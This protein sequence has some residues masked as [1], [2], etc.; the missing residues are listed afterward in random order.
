MRLTYTRH[1]L[2]IPEEGNALIFDMDKMNNCQ[3]CGN[4]QQVYKQ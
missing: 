1:N 4:K 2:G 3:T